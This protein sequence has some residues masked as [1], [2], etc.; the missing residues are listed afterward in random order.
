M[1]LF[2]NRGFSL[3]EL[4]MSLTVTLLIS[5][6]LFAAVRPT[7][8]LF[9]VQTE[10]ADM[11]QRLRVGSSVLFND[12]AVAG[13]GMDAGTP[14]RLSDFLPPLRPYRQMRTG[15]DPPATFR[16]DVV[17]ILFV[18]SLRA[19]TTTASAMAAASGSVRVNL[20]SGCPLT[21]AACGFS[22]ARVVLI[23]DVNG[24]FDLF[25][26]DD[27][28]ESLLA[29]HHSMPDS[30]VVYPAGSRITEVVSRS[31]FLR[32]ANPTDGYQLMRDDGDDRPAVPV[33]DH[34]VQ[35]EFVYWGDPPSPGGELVEL[36][37]A[38]LTDG[39]WRPDATAASRFDADLLRVRRVRV[40]VRVES[41]NDALRGPAGALFVR[42]GTSPGG[43]GFLP[44]H[45]LRFEVAPRNMTRSGE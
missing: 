9:D 2:A 45:V 33:L 10:S 21:D 44:D 35:L 42:G 31:Y 5:A 15:G 41:A 27:V 37:P 20:V 39:P 30:T 11:Q 32:A 19:Q 16:R 28:Q 3:V 29:L 25:R 4:L 22:N 43:H 34:V 17:S 12:L 23:Y 26:V 1:N 13:A 40:T 7:R 14:A 24:S 6:A 36:T 38:M 18:P 8:A